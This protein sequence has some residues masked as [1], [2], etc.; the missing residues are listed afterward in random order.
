[1]QVSVPGIYQNPAPYREQILTYSTALAFT[2]RSA[3]CAPLMATRPAAEPSIRLL[4]NFML[5]LQVALWERRPHRKRPAPAPSEK[6]LS[7]FAPLDNPRPVARDL[8][9]PPHGTI[10]DPQAVAGEYAFEDLIIKIVYLISK[11]I[12]DPLYLFCNGCGQGNSQLQQVPIY[13]LHN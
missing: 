7:R 8:S 13:R 3:A 6:P 10:Q 9:E 11:T 12:D 1:M 4:T 2:G 5:N